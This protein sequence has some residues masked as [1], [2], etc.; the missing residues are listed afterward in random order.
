MVV[1]WATDKDMEDSTVEYTCADGS[2]GQFIAQGKAMHYYLPILIPFYKSPQL[3]CALWH[4]GCS[5]TH[6][7]SITCLL[8][9]LLLCFCSFTLTFFHCPFKLPC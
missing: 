4:V 7:L 9:L 5:H 6:T 1:G 3:H 8:A 2:C